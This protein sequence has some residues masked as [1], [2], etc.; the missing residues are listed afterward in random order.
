MSEYGDLKDPTAGRGKLYSLA[1]WV[2]M[3]F[4]YFVLPVTFFLGMAWVTS[5][6]HG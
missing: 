6:H 3:V 1:F 4:W 2:A 5:G